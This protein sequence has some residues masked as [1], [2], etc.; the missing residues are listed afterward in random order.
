MIYNPTKKELCIINR[1]YSVSGL[2]THQ[3]K[4][5]CVI[6]DKKIL[7]YSHNEGSKSHPN[8]GGKVDK[9]HAEMRALKHIETPTKNASMVIVR[10]SYNK[11][12]MAK[13]CKLCLDLIKDAGIKKVIYSTERGFKVHYV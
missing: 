2:S 12:L 8:L 10:G 9:L 5:G 3:F 11:P 13:P 7:A 1:A 4:L 6:Y